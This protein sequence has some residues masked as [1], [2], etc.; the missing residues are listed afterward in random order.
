MQVVQGVPRQGSFQAGEVVPRA[1]AVLG[2]ASAIAGRAGRI[3][4]ACR[5]IQ[6]FPS[7]LTSCRHSMFKPYSYV[8]RAPFRSFSAAWVTSGADAD[9]SNKP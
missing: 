1:A 9:T 7:I 5:R 6:A 3:R 4:F 8:N 2:N